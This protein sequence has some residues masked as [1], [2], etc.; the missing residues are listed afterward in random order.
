MNKYIKSIRVEKQ[1]INLKPINVYVI[2]DR[3][4]I[5][6]DI[7]ICYDTIKGNDLPMYIFKLRDT[8]LNYNQT[9]Q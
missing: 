8:L 6:S 3:Y 5:H 7:G 1:L 2:N 9:W 4:E